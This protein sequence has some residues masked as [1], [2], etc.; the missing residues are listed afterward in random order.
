MKKLFFIGIVFL[1]SFA[2][3]SQQ[4]FTFKKKAQYGII[5]STGKVTFSASLSFLAQANSNRFFA[6]KEGA[7]KYIDPRG[8]EIH[9]NSLSGFHVVNDKISIVK[10]NGF[11]KILNTESDSLYKNKFLDIEITKEVVAGIT[12]D[13]VFYFSPE[14]KLILGSNSRLKIKPRNK[15]N[16]VYLKNSK[17]QGIIHPESD[18]MIWFDN[19]QITR[20]YDI[21]TIEDQRY[22]VSKQGFL[23]SNSP[24]YR[25]KRYWGLEIIET[26]ESSFLIYD[27]QEITKLEGIKDV[28]WTWSKNLL[29]ITDTE[30]NIG[31]YDYKLK[32]QTVS[33]KYKSINS[34]W[35]YRLGKV[36]ETSYEI[37]DE[38]YSKFGSFQADNIQLATQNLIYFYRNNKMGIFSIPRNRVIIPPKYEAVEY[39]ALNNFR[40]HNNGKVGVMSPSGRILVPNKYLKVEIEKEKIKAY[41]KKNSLEVYYLE[42]GKVKDKSSFNNVVTG[43]IRVR[44]KTNYKTWKTDKEYKTRILPVVFTSKFNTAAHKEE[45]RQKGWY[46]N[47]I[48]TSKKVYVMKW[49][50]KDSNDKPKLKPSSVRDVFLLDSSLAVV[51]TIRKELVGRS[52]VT[53]EDRITTK[54]YDTKKYKY[55]RIRLNT[56]LKKDLIQNK[57]KVLGFYNNH[58][59]L[60]S[61]ERLK[62]IDT[63][64]Y[65][66]PIFNQNLHFVAKRGKT[67]RCLADDPLMA[68]SIVDLNNWLQDFDSISP[69]K[70]EDYN[71]K[72]KARTKK[73]NRNFLKVKDA[74]WGVY[75]TNWNEVVPPIYDFIY[76]YSA[77]VFIAKNEEKKGLISLDTVVFL[78]DNAELERLRSEDD[79]LFMFTKGNRAN[80]LINEKGEIQKGIMGVV[81]YKPLDETR[82]AIRKKLGWSVLDYSTQAEV[83]SEQYS[84]IDLL[85][86]G[87]FQLKKGREIGLANSD[88]NVVFELKKYEELELIT[89]NFAKAKNKR[90]WG[91]INT[92][93]DTVIP[94]EF[95]QIVVNQEYIVAIK[96]Q[97]F[98][99]FDKKLNPIV[100]KEM[101]FRGINNHLIALEKNGKTKVFDL[102]TNK[103]LKK[104]IQGKTFLGKNF[105]IAKTNRYLIKHSLV[106]TYNIDTL[107]DW[108]DIE[109]LSTNLYLAKNVD[110]KKWH[111]V[112]SNFKTIS[113]QGFRRLKKIDERFYTYFYK[114]NVQIFDKEK[115]QI[116]KVN[117]PAIGVMSYNR[118]LFLCMDRNRK[119][120]Y[121]DT[122]GNQLLENRFDN[123]SRFFDD[124]AVTNSRGKFNFINREGV[125]INS[126]WHYGKIESINASLY[127]A[128][129]YNLYGIVDNKG[130]ILIPN[131]YQLLKLIGN[132]W[133]QAFKDNTITYY[134]L[135][136][137]KWLVK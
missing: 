128:Q 110:D 99:V 90:K 129:S 79:S 54:F 50:F 106:S 131:E 29:Q 9:E 89:E 114:G 69:Y 137:R 134:N 38:D 20:L 13:S 36:D 48:D 2:S 62:I 115:E 125:L 75:D 42:N 126:F 83:I 94:F 28:K 41:P 93:Q 46:N 24:I 34:Y 45:A 101:I 119:Y 40:F 95:E 71:Y 88:G 67:L 12:L 103:Y 58:F 121:L 19:L 6:Y 44:R 52:P 74:K 113:N 87:Y 118:G 4:H 86:N 53:Y 22:L 25:T 15:T 60:V 66:S 82:I 63:L 39:D 73:V 107:S 127:R 133:V 31:V 35:R 33:N 109:S 112:D 104:K 57:S 123:A 65:I 7:W 3:S 80:Y 130:N 100:D 16:S 23:M 68:T 27:N 14:G 78:L 59:H 32:Q 26:L 11:W 135:K 85:P 108:N 30:D 64:N 98:Q 77:G 76:P 49:G 5:D 124:I 1:W 21:G 136:T 56:V 61:R 43:T 51:Y 120:F 91:V 84:R 116:I 105:I 18:T 10:E 96:K 92:N 122:N 70:F 81:D 132:H 72:W 8:N 102:K 111:I 97:S 37:L 55:K 47:E 17:K 117:Y